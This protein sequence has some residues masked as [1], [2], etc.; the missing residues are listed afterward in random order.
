MKGHAGRRKRERHEG[1]R[2]KVRRGCLVKQRMGWKE[3]YGEREIEGR[4]M[5]QGTKLEGMM[6][7]READKEGK[8]C[9][10]NV[11]LVLEG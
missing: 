8:G 11:Y 9:Y 5:R 7:G 6:E 3:E 4:E 2:E 10:F 1:G